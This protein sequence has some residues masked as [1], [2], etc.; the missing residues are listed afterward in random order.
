MVVKE[1][2]FRIQCFFSDTAQMSLKFI[3]VYLGGLP[4]LTEFMATAKLGFKEDCWWSVSSTSS[5][6][7]KSASCVACAENRNDLPP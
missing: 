4:V 5:K 3:I 1:G 6:L 7:M 2:I